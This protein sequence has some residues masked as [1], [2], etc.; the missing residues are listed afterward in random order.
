MICSTI[1]FRFN[2]VGLVSGTVEDEAVFGFTVR[3]HMTR[4]ICCIVWLKLYVF[5]SA[6]VFPHP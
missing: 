1:V 4:L 2:F 3:Y 5:A 6:F